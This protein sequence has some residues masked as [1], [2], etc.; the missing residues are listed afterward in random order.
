ML[1]YKD[2]GAGDGDPS[3]EA[4]GDGVR[5]IGVADGVVGAVEAPLV[6]RVHQRQD[7]EGQR[8]CKAERRWGPR[9]PA[10]S[11]HAGTQHHTISPSLDPRA[12][13]PAA[14][15]GFPLGT[16]SQDTGTQGRRTHPPPAH[17]PDTDRALSQL[18]AACGAQ[19]PHETATTR[20]LQSPHGCPLLPRRSHRRA[21]RRRLGLILCPL[22][23][24][25][26]DFRPRR[27]ELIR[28][29][30]HRHLGNLL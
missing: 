12:P 20:H 2:N 9:T 16:R 5:L 8:R 30:E 19:I 7:D 1:P 4:M 22:L 24:L 18:P 10:R 26:R 25:P 13:L 17:R 29:N 15:E 27:M 11:L 6:R 14:G 28:I 21:S 23:P 3:H